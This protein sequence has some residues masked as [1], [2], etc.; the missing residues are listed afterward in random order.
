IR[1]QK[2]SG[3]TRSIYAM[4]GDERDAL[5]IKRVEG[6]EYIDRVDTIQRPYKLMAKDSE[7]AKHEITVNGRVVGNGHFT[8]VAGHCT[9]DP[10]HPEYF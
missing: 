10:E 3:E 8:V 5:L 7:L 6:L 9:I 4:L 1:L 2:I